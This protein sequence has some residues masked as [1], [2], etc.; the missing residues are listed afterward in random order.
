MR[1]EIVVAEE[2]PGCA[3]AR[4]IAAE[5]QARFPGLQVDVSALDST[6]PVP[7]K[8]VA[9]PTYLL[10]GRVISLGNPR[11]AWLIQEI[12]RQYA[13]VADR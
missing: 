7:A 13:S 10:N 6:R 3:E 11:R 9:T 5:I 4:A 1:L 2:C 12:G 8:V